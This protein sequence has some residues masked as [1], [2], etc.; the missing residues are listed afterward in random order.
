MGARHPR[1]DWFARVMFLELDHGDKTD[2]GEGKVQVQHGWDDE[3][4]GGVEWSG[5]GS[6]RDARPRPS[7]KRAKSETNDE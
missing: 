6:P 7:P 2:F 5:G 3:G 1:V 4:G